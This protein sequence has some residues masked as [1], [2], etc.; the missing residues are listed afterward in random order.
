MASEINNSTIGLVQDSHEVAH[1]A[2]LPSHTGIE[3]HREYF[4]DVVRFQ[5]GFELGTWLS[6]R[7]VQA[8][9]AMVVI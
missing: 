9:R 8:Y 7:K 5:V 1:D 2:P 6:G 3:D 4:W